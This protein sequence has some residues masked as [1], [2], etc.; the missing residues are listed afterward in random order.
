M[1]L[2]VTDKFINQQIA[3]NVRGELNPIVRYT[4]LFVKKLFGKLIYNGQGEFLYSGVIT[5]LGKVSLP[6][7]ISN[8]IS[9]I[10]FFPA[11]SPITKTGCA[12]VSYGTNLYISWGRTIKESIV[13]KIFFRKLVKEG[14][15][16]KIETN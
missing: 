4:P 13:E 3:R 9:D 7:V 11:P 15:E 1:R 5:N 8:E 12:V 16:V 14:I 10:H 2:E 6:E